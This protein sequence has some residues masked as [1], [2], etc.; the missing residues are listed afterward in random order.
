MSKGSRVPSGVRTFGHKTMSDK[1]SKHPDTIGSG[2][3]GV[4][5][6]GGGSTDVK[7][8]AAGARSTQPKGVIRGDGTETL[9]GTEVKHKQGSGTKTV[10]SGSKHYPSEVR[11]HDGRKAPRSIK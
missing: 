1:G 6:Q 10:Y 3:Q 5:K 9:R 11:Q 2:L 7:G 4:D 8:Y